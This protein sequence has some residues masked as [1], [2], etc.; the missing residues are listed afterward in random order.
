MSN[1]KIVAVVDDDESVRESLPALLE[2]FGF[3]TRA[4]AS[5]EQYLAGT[6]TEVPD[7]L[8]LDVAMP[9]MTGPELYRELVRQRRDIPT[10]F[11]TAHPNEGTGPLSIDSEAT[12]W[13]AKPF[14]ETDIVDAVRAALLRSS[15]R[16]D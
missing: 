6:E 10:I 4:F 11:I 5:A 1:N 16:D 15:R 8:I 13:L 9:G 3:E 2:S 7:C 12:P 14:S